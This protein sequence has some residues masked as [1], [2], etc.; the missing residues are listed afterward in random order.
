VVQRKGVRERMG[1]LERVAEC[2][3]LKMLEGVV[4]GVKNMGMF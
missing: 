1:V 2:Y 4:R 3:G